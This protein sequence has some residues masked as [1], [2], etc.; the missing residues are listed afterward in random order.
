M[1]SSCFN[2]LFE[3]VETDI[4]P[5]PFEKTSKFKILT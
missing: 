4:Q 2:A 1:I 3:Q 5:L